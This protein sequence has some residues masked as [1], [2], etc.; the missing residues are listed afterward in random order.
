MGN[1][2]MMSEYIIATLWILGKDREGPVEAV[3]TCELHIVDKLEANMLVGIDIMTPE[4][5]DILLSEKVLHIGTC[6]IDVPIQVQIRTGYQQHLH[7]V[8]TKSTTSIPPHSIMA[9]SIHALPAFAANRDFLFKPNELDYVSLFSH[10]VNADVKGILVK[11]DTNSSVIIPR[12]S[13]L[14][15]LQEI[16]VEQGLVASAFSATEDEDLMALAEWPP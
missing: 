12:N 6:R 13:R 3:L 4:K 5:M 1:Q 2:H 8:H 7:P 10:V 14:G 11:N 16:G 9:V 15:H